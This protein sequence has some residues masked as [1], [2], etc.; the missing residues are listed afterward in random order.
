MGA[1]IQLPMTAK[2]IRDL[3]SSFTG[4]RPVFRVAAML[5]RRLP[6]Y[7]SCLGAYQIQ[8]TFHSADMPF[9]HL[10]ISLGGTDRA[11]TQKHLNGTNVIAALQKMRG[12]GM[13]KD[14]GCNPLFNPCLLSRF[15]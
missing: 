9:A 15:V 12:K 4:V 14:M 8:G 11:V 13:P 7:F 6:E 5:Q 3:E 1:P 2:N 10:Y